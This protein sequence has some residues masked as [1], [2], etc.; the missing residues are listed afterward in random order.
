MARSTPRRRILYRWNEG[1]FNG[2]VLDAASLK[3]AFTPVK[4]EEKQGI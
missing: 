3:A 1:L 2:R 4:T